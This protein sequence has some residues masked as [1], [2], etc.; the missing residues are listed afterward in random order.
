LIALSAIAIG[1]I[2]SFSLSD[3]SSSSSR[4]AALAAAALGVFV[5]WDGLRILT[6]C[7]RLTAS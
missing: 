4:Y 2:A 7:L 1:A 3:S 6:A 5:A